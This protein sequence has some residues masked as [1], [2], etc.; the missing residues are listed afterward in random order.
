MGSALGKGVG[1]EC[2]AGLIWLLRHSTPFSPILNKYKQTN[3]RE[4]AVLEILESLWLTEAHKTIESS[5]QEFSV[6]LCLPRIPL[7]P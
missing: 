2:F 7:F 4:M 1:M 3:F 5:G 6:N